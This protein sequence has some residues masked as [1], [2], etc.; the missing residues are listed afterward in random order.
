MV[1]P[2]F[3]FFNGDY[4][5][6][7]KLVTHLLT[8]LPVDDLHKAHVLDSGSLHHIQQSVAARLVAL[9]GPAKMNTGAVGISVERDWRMDPPRGTL[10]APYQGLTRAAPSD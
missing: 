8:D 3:S 6:G 1:L 2:V 5:F 10:D 9:L 4:A 7:P